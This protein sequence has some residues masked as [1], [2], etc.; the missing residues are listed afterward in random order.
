LSNSSRENVASEHDVPISA[1]VMFDGP[2]WPT[3]QAIVASLAT[4]NLGLDVVPDS[5][6]NRNALVLSAHG[7]LYSIMKFE[8]PCPISAADSCVTGSWWWPKAWDT[9][10]GHKAHM[11]FSSSGDGD[12]KQRSII[13]AELVASTLEHSPAL[14][15]HWA[16]ADAL[17]R[18]EAFIEIMRNSSGSLPT[19]ICVSI[20]LA[21]DTG[22]AKNNAKPVLMAVTCGLTAFG[23]MEIEVRDYAG[24]ARDLH[25]IM[26]DLADYII[27]SRNIVGDGDTIG[28]DAKTK[29]KLSVQDSTLLPQQKVYRLYIQ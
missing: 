22:L 15:V 4:R 18:P 29:F 5:I 13:L 6:A 1:I 19:A 3:N 11:V 9:L 17:W 23:I 20:R 27:E 24:K 10:R 28:P 25:P 2:R 16:P 7:H 21:R 26:L 8:A 12:A 14:G